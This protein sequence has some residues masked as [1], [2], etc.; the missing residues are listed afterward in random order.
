MT[1]TGS[2][3]ASMVTLPPRDT[4]EPLIVMLEL[5][6]DEL[7][8]LDKVLLAPLIV[9]LVKVCAVLKSTVTFVSMLRVTLPEVPPPDRPVPAVTAVM[10]PVDVNTTQA[11]P[12]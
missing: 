4:A 5:V 9:L 1:Y 7:P 11:L 2:V 12:E 10:S 3:P 8:I 6:K